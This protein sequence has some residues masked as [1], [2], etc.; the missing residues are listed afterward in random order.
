VAPSFSKLPWVTTAMVES[1]PSWAAVTV[2]VVGTGS[3]AR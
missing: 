3:A 2:A 1:V